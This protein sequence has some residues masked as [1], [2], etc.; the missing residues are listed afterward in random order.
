VG[1]DGH[2][3]GASSPRREL[4][5]HDAPLTRSDAPSIARTCRT[6]RVE[7]LVDGRRAGLQ[8]KALGELGD[9]VEQRLW[10]AA[11]R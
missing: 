8:A 4:V 3:V 2:G 9:G 6:T 1:G 11:M 7:A 10:R 5:R